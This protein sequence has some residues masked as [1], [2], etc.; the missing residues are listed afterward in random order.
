MARV[1][2]SRGPY[3]TVLRCTRCGWFEL[4]S[5]SYKVPVCP[6]CGRVTCESVGRI[7]FKDTKHWFWGRR[8]E[9]V[10]FISGLPPS[11]M[12]PEPSPPPSRDVGIFG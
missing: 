7:L 2:F 1:T 10:R 8:V 4:P 5:D 3:T 11:G 6:K 12:R 9:A